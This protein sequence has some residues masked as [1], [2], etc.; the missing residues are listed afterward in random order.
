VEMKGNA[1]T[2]LMKTLI[3][4]KPSSKLATENS[5]T[6]LNKSIKFKSQFSKEEIAS[7]PLKSDSPTPIGTK[8]ALTMLG[9]NVNNNNNSPSLSASSSTDL[10]YQKD[11]N[12]FEDIN[13]FKSDDTINNNLNETKKL[14]AI[15][16]A[17]S[18]LATTTDY[19]DSISPVT[20]SFGRTISLNENLKEENDQLNIKKQKLYD[21]SNNSSGTAGRKN[22]VLLKKLL[23][24]NNRQD[25]SPVSCLFNSLTSSAM[26]NNNNNN[27]N[28]RSQSPIL[29]MTE[30]TVDLQSTDLDLSPI[31]GDEIENE[32]IHSS[33]PMGLE[34]EKE[35][36]QILFSSLSNNNDKQQSNN[37]SNQF[38]S[39][40]SSSMTSKDD[41]ILRTLLNT[42]DLE[43]QV[44]K[45]ESV[46]DLNSTTTTTNNNNNNN[47][48]KKELIESQNQPPLPAIGLSKSISTPPPTTS[49]KVSSYSN[50]ASDQFSLQITA[51][52]KTRKRKKIIKQPTVT[53]LGE[54]GTLKNPSIGQM[55]IT[56]TAVAKATSKKL[57]AKNNK[58]NLEYEY[59][60]QQHQQQLLFNNSNEKKQNV[61][62][63]NLKKQTS[64]SLLSKTNSKANNFNLKQIL[65]GDEEDQ[66]IKKLNNNNCDNLIQHFKVEQRS[67]SP[68]TIISNAN[69]MQPQQQQQQQQQHLLQNQQHSYHHYQNPINQQPQTIHYLNSD[70]NSN[71]KMNN[72][73]EEKIFSSSSLSSS[74]TSVSSIS[75]L[76]SPVNIHNTSTNTATTTNNNNNNMNLNTMNHNSNLMNTLVIGSNG[77]EMTINNNLQHNNLNSTN[78][79]MPHQD[80]YMNNQQQHV[81]L[82]LNLTNDLLD[83][84]HLT[85]KSNEND[86]SSKYMTTSSNMDDQFYMETNSAITNQR[87]NFSQLNW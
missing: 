45:L 42:A 25:K 70:S 66:E 69:N 82:N 79:N 87:A 12:E 19:T 54:S 5:T 77:N 53:D 81:F 20:S 59:Q 60:Q 76:S 36:K 8:F 41:I 37:C 39:S 28:N 7:S 56:T 27:K 23:S 11:S 50:L 83:D 34:K 67:L 18:I 33:S 31:L 15:E 47:K 46:F 85:S 21:T 78:D 16:P 72:I 62:A 57:T 74:T 22:N 86:D 58:L 64:K 32:S 35:L 43:P 73:K 49:K 52:D 80:Y 55:G 29:S 44:L 24:T 9:L 48:I 10:I 75:S 6:F 14:I 40:S 51:N 26:N 4:K 61:S 2:S 84:F 1:S 13:D 17:S 3:G 65:I 71:I 63:I 30:Q 68:T 38:K